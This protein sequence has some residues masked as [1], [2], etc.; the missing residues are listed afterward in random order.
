M[1]LVINKAEMVKTYRLLAA[2]REL[3]VNEGFP[4]MG[5]LGRSVLAISGPR[6]GPGREGK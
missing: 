1:S 6:V 2:V 3:E 4:G 5:V